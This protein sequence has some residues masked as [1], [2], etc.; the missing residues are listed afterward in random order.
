MKKLNRIEIT[1]EEL[2]TL[3]AAQAITEAIAQRYQDAN[4]GRWDGRVDIEMKIAWAADDTPNC[5]WTVHPYLESM[6]SGHHR[7]LDL[8]LEE[9]HGRTEGYVKRE[10]AKRYIAAARRLQKEAREL[11]A[12]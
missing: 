10:Q 8:A 1:A 9:M 4:G 6:Q 12:A 5:W 7:S 11:E 2:K 3:K